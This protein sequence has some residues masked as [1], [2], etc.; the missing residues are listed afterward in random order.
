MMNGE[1]SLDVLLR[2]CCRIY[3]YRPSSMFIERA[4]DHPGGAPRAI[5]LLFSSCSC[6]S[7]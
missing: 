5:Y 4:R 2:F 3:R 7:A 1:R 6:I